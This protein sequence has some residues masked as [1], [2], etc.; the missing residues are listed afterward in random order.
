MQIP[1]RS[2]GLRRH[3]RQKCPKRCKICI[4]LAGLAEPKCSLI[5]WAPCDNSDLQYW[6]SSTVNV[7]Q[8][9]ARFA[10]QGFLQKWSY[11]QWMRVRFWPTQLEGRSFHGSFTPLSCWWLF[12]LTPYLLQIYNR[13]CVCVR[14]CRTQTTHTHLARWVKYTKGSWLT[15]GIQWKEEYQFAVNL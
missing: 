4:N 2:D 13:V 10:L 8:A 6:R 3:G 12:L 15:G 9:F 14:M 5:I 1:L 11:T 7:F